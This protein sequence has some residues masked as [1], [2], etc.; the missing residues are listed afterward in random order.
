[1]GCLIAYLGV[2]PK[3][4]ESR[5]EGA[6][7]QDSFPSRHCECLMQRWETSGFP[8]LSSRPH[9]LEMDMVG[10]LNFPL[11]W[12]LRVKRM[13]GQWWLLEVA[14]GITW[15]KSGVIRKL[16]FQSPY[17]EENVG[18]QSRGSLPIANISVATFQNF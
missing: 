5:G 11:Q 2:S 15:R 17:S 8:N 4:P 12:P 3:S 6:A 13:C 18:E 14:V 9:R 10:F 1:M 7:A 16:T